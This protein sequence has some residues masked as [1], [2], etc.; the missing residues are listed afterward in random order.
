MPEQAQWLAIAAYMLLS[1]RLRRPFPKSMKAY[2]PGLHP[3][4]SAC[5]LLG[6][7]KHSMALLQVS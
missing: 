2:L 7:K 3:A 5:A 6:R 4:E 1:C